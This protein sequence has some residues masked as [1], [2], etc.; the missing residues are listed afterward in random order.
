MDSK[1]INLRLSP[2]SVCKLL[3]SFS[4]DL[5]PAL[6]PGDRSYVNKIQSITPILPCQKWPVD[7]VDGRSSKETKSIDQ[8]EKGREAETE[9]INRLIIHIIPPGKNN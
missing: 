5:V 3:F 4:Y 6:L 9:V 1:L 7:E 2:A 8:E